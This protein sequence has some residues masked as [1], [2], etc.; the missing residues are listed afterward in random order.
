MGGGRR[1]RTTPPPFQCDLPCKTNCT[2]TS[3]T[4]MI[5]RFS[6][7][8]YRPSYF[9]STATNITQLCQLVEKLLRIQT[10]Y[11]QESHSEK[12]ACEIL[13][14]HTTVLLQ[15][16][17]SPGYTICLKHSA[18]LILPPLLKPPSRRT[19]LITISKLFFTALPIPSSDTVCVC[20]CTR[21]R[22]CVC[23]RV[24]MCVCVCG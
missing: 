17:C 8:S 20:V 18:T 15:L 23:V 13:V 10:G 16:V 6:T 3:D 7:R 4:F 9:H 24:C 2:D 19:C 11:C 5:F 12:L 14:M 1:D 21:A 22:A